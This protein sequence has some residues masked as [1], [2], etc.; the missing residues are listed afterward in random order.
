M[1]RRRWKER[2][3]NEWG[4]VPEREYDYA[5]LEKISRYFEYQLKKREDNRAIY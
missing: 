4:T 3:Q 1:R 2:F 5:E